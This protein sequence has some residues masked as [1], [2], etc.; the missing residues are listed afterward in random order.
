MIKYIKGVEVGKPKQHPVGMTSVGDMNGACLNGPADW[1]SLATVNFDVATDPWASAPPAADGRKVDLLDTD[2]IGWK[3]FIKD[4]KF[5]RTWIWKSFTRGHNSLLMENLSDS[6][7]WIA[8]RATMG[9]TRQYAEKM[10]LAAMKPQNE[11]SSTGYCLANT[12]SEYLIYQPGSGSFTVNLVAGTYW[13][14]WFDPEAGTV[15][16]SDAVTAVGGNKS[17]NPPLSGEAVIYLRV[18]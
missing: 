17:F 12:G 13:Y 6:A 4:A 1:T 10:N 18:T 2:H 11:L 8:G 9:H 14:E 7:G 16:G 15:V 5:T 3:I